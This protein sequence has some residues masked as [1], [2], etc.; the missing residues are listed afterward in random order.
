MVTEYVSLTKVVS[1]AH[2]S[3]VIAPL[4][5]TLIVST[6]TLTCCSNADLGSDLKW[7]V[8]ISKGWYDQVVG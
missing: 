3:I 4:R 2:R 8:I 1:S 6:T 5:V 7:L